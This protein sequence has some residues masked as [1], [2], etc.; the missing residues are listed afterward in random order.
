[1]RQVAKLQLLCAKSI[2]FHLSVIT[3][4]NDL[5]LIPPADKRAIFAQIRNK[6]LLYGQPFRSLVCG[7]LM[8]HLDLSHATNLAHED[9][10]TISA[11]L[12]VCDTVNLSGCDQLD[13]GALSVLLSTRLVALTSLNC[14]DMELTGSTLVDTAHQMPNLRHL[15]VAN[16]R[17]FVTAAVSAI[18]KHCPQLISL[19]VSNCVK[20]ADEALEAVAGGAVELLRLKG[21]GRLS[22]E[23]VC[24]TIQR[25]RA[26]QVL[27]V[28][29]C[30]FAPDQFVRVV[31]QSGL[32]L[33][34]LDIGGLGNCDT[35]YDSCDDSLQLLC[36]SA[37]SESLTELQICGFQITD[38]GAASIVECHKMR[39][40]GLD[41][42]S[43]LSAGAA[44][45]IARA[46][47]QLT[48]MGFSRIPDISNSIKFLIIG[49]L[50]TNYEA[51]KLA[52]KD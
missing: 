43:E 37:M 4:R 3:R 18:G 5:S 6:R 15:Y 28:R 20:L 27:D 50:D 38:A 10:A 52:G 40:L 19:D 24:A 49:A 41:G 36:N 16:T 39:A 45:G 12:S 11:H 25:C 23:V 29:N 33:R 32:Q 2:A 7:S 35:L 17:T 42:C 22:L 51:L 13:D 8:Q 9:I 30:S 47:H 21:C 1:V 31:A 34:K 44:L 26:L 14:S 48:S 46:C